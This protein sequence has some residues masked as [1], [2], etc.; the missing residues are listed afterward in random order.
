MREPTGGPL[1][2]A[3][4]LAVFVRSTRLNLVLSVLFIFTMGACGDLGG[5][6]A[7]GAVQP[8]PA[9]GLP[10][11]QTVEGGA[12]IRVTPAG[13]QKLTSILPGARQLRSSAAASACRAARPA[14]R[15]AR[16]A[17]AP[18]ACQ[19]QCQRLQPGL[20]GRTSSINPSGLTT[21]V[22]GPQRLRVNLS[23]S[24]SSTLRVRG[25]VLGIE[26]RSLHAQRQLEQPRRQLRHRVRHQARRRRARHP[27]RAINQFNLNIDFSGL[28]PRSPTSP[29]LVDATSSTRSSA[30][31]SSTC[32]RRSIDDVLQDFLPSPL[33]IAGMMDVGTLLEGVSPGTEGFMEA[34]IVPGGY[35]RLDATAA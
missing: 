26:R 15:S 32:S 27:P 16:S 6:G 7:C 4:R 20:Q 31:S 10:A 33:G 13:F 11:S 14:A 21:S 18:S 23:T 12:Q 19:H 5:C 17:P 3:G 25:Q 24:I 29:N 1:G 8:L 34:R 35:V 9:G 28:R 30:S 22:I 2:F